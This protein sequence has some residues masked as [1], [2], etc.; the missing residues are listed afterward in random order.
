[1][2]YVLIL[3]SLTFTLNI[4][5]KDEKNNSEKVVSLVTTGYGISKDEA[6]QMALRDALEQAFGV[7]ISTNTKISN[8]DII[9]DEMTS[10]SNGNIQDFEVL[11]ELKSSENQWLVT[12]KSTV[13][14]TELTSFV[15]NNVTG[16]NAKFKGNLFAFNVNQQILNEQN[17]I[18]AIRKTCETVKMLAENSFEY[19]ISASEPFSI[20]GGNNDWAIPLQVQVYKNLNFDRLST[21]LYSTLKG[22]SLSIDEAKNY[23]SLNKPVFPITIASA[24]EKI[25]FILL[26]KEESRQEIFKTLLFFR[27]AVE[28]FKISNGVTSFTSLQNRVEYYN[29]KRLNKGVDDSRFELFQRSSSAKSPFYA[30]FWNNERVSQYYN[31]KLGR[32]ISTYQPATPKVKSMPINTSIP[33]KYYLDDK[34]RFVYD[35]KSEIESIG[36]G[37]G[38]IISF[39]PD[40]YRRNKK[41]KK[42]VI[43]DVILTIYYKDQKTLEEINRIEE[44]IVVKKKLTESERL[45][46]W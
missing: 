4:Y 45:Q 37:P 11:S 10:L 43:N 18:K 28:D 27:E 3:L 23:I 32:Y 26:R 33:S 12:L 25:A 36:N 9:S 44:Y 21:L 29:N 17:E 2:R 39:L 41:K 40:Y 31:R 19:N 34:F 7:F 8:D 35:L 14:I 30:N 38:L 6:K 1:M 15:N 46:R 20:D 16:V 13:S 24:D 22:I 42:W 5:S